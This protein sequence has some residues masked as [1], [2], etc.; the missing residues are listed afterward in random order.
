MIKKTL[1]GAKN[2]IAPNRNAKVATTA[3]TNSESKKA[4]SRIPYGA[5]SRRP[6]LSEIKKEQ[7]KNNA[8]NLP[9]IKS[10]DVDVAKVNVAN[11]DNKVKKVS[12]GSFWSNTGNYPDFENTDLID[13]GCGR[14][15]LPYPVEYYDTVPISTEYRTILM[16]NAVESIYLNKFGKK[17]KCYIIKTVNSIVMTKL[18]S[19]DGYYKLEWLMDRVDIVKKV[20]AA[21]GNVYLDIKVTDE[22]GAKIIRV[23]SSELTNLEKYGIQCNINRDMTIKVYLNKLAKSLPM[24]DASQVIGV[25]KD[26]KSHNSFVFN[27]YTAEDAFKTH[28]TFDSYEEYINRFNVLIKHS[29][30]IQFLLSATMAAPVLTVLQQK[31]NMDLHSY[32]INIV[33]ASSTGKTISSRLCASAWTKPMDE[34]IFGAMLATGNASLKRLSGRY[35][36]PTFF[37]EATVHGNTKPEEYIYSVYEG[38][39][40][41]RLNPDCSEKASGTWSTIICITMFLF[42]TRN[43]R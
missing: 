38:R 36:I 20:R 26:R 4:V 18:S 34:K 14:K 32:I 22:L 7:S 13:D 9:T 25:V 31:Y 15:C 43:G 3:T 16:K 5:D 11:S 8:V 21:D 35:G 39:E 42:C 41:K 23:K 27:G 2:S 24:E 37:D 40:K 17:A 30:P 10:S 29:A 19:S 28:N 33:G 1:N 6:K 12:I